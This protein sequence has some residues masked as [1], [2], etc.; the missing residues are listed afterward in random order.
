MTWISLIIFSEPQ[1]F[2]KK[3]LPYRQQDIR[4][5]WISL[6]IFSEP[7]SFGKKELPYRP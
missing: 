1:S 3:E 5:T 6:I 7:Q 4:M 2:G